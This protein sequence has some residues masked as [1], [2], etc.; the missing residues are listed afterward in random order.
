LL[1]DADIINNIEE[2]QKD[3]KPTEF[4]EFIPI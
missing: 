3:V 4:E 2:K 1:V